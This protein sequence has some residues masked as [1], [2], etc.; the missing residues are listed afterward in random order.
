MDYARELRC[1]DRVVEVVIRRMRRKTMAIHVY[2]DQ[3]V[4]LRAP[5]RCSTRELDAFLESRRQ[6]IAESLDE[7]GS[8]TALRSLRYTD[9]EIVPWLGE[10]YRLRLTAGRRNVSVV[11]DLLAVRCP[12]PDEADC[13]RT[14]IEQFYRRESLRLF[15]RRIDVCRARFGDGLPASTLKV[16]KMK[17]R[18]GSCSSEGEICLNTLLMQKSL[19]AI[20]FVMT[21][22]LCHLVHFAH[23]KSF[24]RLMD[25]SMPDWRER[26][27]LL[28]ADDATV[29]L[30][31][32]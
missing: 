13:V 2:A 6:W 21:H 10:G 4:E 12:S 7:L 1:G 31:L 19:A 22:E 15:P 16:R 32:L 24:Y 29:Q 17:S 30:D 28:V 14:T 9:G 18:W 23:N 25:R 11:G 27:R 3:P 5:K 8:D 20:D 26:E